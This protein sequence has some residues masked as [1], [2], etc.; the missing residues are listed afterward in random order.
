MPWS[1]NKYN[2]I[3][4]VVPVQSRK[5]Y[6][7]EF[8]LF[9][10]RYKELTMY[11]FIDSSDYGDHDKGTW[12]ICYKQEVQETLKS[13]KDY[14]DYYA[15]EEKIAFYFNAI[16]D[17]CNDHEI[18]LLV[19]KTP[20]MDRE[21][22]QGYY[23]TVELIANDKGVPFLDMNQYDNE[24][25]IVH[26]DFYN[27]LSHLNISGARKTARFLG[28][29]L[30]ARYQIDDHRGLAEYKSWDLFAAHREAMY[31]REIS[32]PNDYLNELLRQDK[33]VLVFPNKGWEDDSV[34]KDKSFHN[35]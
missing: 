35:C 8:P 26:S 6:F 34:E 31:L 22:K 21:A 16:I 3:N 5:D 28:K 15:I 24:I 11:D 32:D 1:I 20:N 4:A 17:Y 30:K 29:Y 10:T 25:G 18:S 14:V 9:H 2:Y 19:V 7:L 23:N 13:A 33:D 12:S 27:D